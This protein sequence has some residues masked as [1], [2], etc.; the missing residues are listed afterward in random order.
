MKK[1]NGHKSYT[2]IDVYHCTECNVDLPL[3][4]AEI[5]H[6]NMIHKPPP[7][8]I[9]GSKVHILMKRGSRSSLEKIRIFLNMPI[10][11]FLA[12]EIVVENGHI[13]FIAPEGKNISIQSNN[14][15]WTDGWDLEKNSTTDKE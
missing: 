13:R 6:N 2:Y 8:L 11:T 4:S 10:E 1:G 14:K 3:D 15:R 7:P 5:D 12:Y 9:C